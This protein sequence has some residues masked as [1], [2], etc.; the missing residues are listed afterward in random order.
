MRALYREAAAARGIRAH[1]GRPA[2]D[3]ARQPAPVG[4]SAT[5]DETDT[6]VAVEPVPQPPDQEPLVKVAPRFLL[7]SLPLSGFGAHFSSRSKRSQFYTIRLEI[8]FTATTSL[9]GRRR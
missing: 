3:T 2:M 6:L 4:P 8:A 7:L 9:L 1:Q 5:S